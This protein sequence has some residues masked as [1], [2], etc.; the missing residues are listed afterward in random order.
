MPGVGPAGVGARCPSLPGPRAAA[1]RPPVR[2]RRLRRRPRPA[3]AVLG[4]HEAGPWPPAAETSRA[5]NNTCFRRARKAHVPRGGAAACARS[6]RGS[7]ERA[8]F[9]PL[10][11]QPPMPLPNLTQSR[12]RSDRRRAGPPLFSMRYFYAAKLGGVPQGKS[13][14]RIAPRG[15]RGLAPP[16]QEV[17]PDPSPLGVFRST[18]S[19]ATLVPLFCYA[20]GLRPLRLASGSLISLA[21][22]LWAGW[23]RARGKPNGAHWPAAG[24]STGFQKARSPTPVVR[25][26]RRG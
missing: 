26:V 11:R 18:T 2:P 16:P 24:F 19:L 4:R 20:G 21:R 3:G 10:R 23:E 12:G 8:R 6:L 13:R 15:E 25:P 9:L 22:G 1:S 14:A 5:Q 17:W 7:A